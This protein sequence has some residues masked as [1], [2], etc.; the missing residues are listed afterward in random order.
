MSVVICS[1]MVMVKRRRG[2]RHVICPCLIKGPDN[3]IELF[4]S[5]AAASEA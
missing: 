3:V 5:E 4:L 1:M 2:G